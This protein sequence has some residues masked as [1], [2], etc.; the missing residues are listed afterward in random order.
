MRRWRPES[1][2]VAALLREDDNEGGGLN[3]AKLPGDLGRLLERGDA[4]RK[5][6]MGQK[7]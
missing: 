7:Q 5:K 6:E 4:G 2:S 1:E 3:W